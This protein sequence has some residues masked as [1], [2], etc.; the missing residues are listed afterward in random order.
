VVW[1]DNYRK[2][3]PPGLDLVEIQPHCLAEP[4]QALSPLSIQSF[5]IGFGEIPRPIVA[6]VLQI[7]NERSDAVAVRIEIMPLCFILLGPI[8][9]GGLFDLRCLADLVK[10]VTDR[11]LRERVVSVRPAVFEIPERLGKLRVV[12]QFEL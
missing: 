12:S 1:D 9:L 2:I 8:I 4:R 7:Y 5:E 3:S 6:K 10:K 11:S